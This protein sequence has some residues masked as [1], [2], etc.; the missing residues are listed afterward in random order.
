VRHSTALGNLGIRDAQL[1]APGAA[2]RSVLPL[3]MN[4]RGVAE[5][6][7]PAGLGSLVDTEGVALIRAWIDSLTSCD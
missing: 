5:A 6:M 7:P 4:L 1:V 3:R 2:S